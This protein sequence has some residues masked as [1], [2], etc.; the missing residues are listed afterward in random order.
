MNDGP[1]KGTLGGFIHR[2]AWIE[3]FWLSSLC[4]VLGLH[5]LG[6]SARLLV[7]PLLILFFVLLSLRRFAYGTW[8]RRSQIDWPLLLLFLWVPIAYWAAADKDLAWHGIFILLCGLTLAGALSQSPPLSRHPQWYAQALIAIGGLFMILS[9][10]YFGAAF[11]PVLNLPEMLDAAASGLR[12]RVNV[13]DLAGAVALLAP[14]MLAQ[15]IGQQREA[16][17]RRLSTSVLA[18]ALVVVVLYS[19]SVGAGVALGAGCAVVLLW[20]WPNL[21]YTAPILALCGAIVIWLVGY[22][23]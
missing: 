14:I 9:A 18:L 7:W 5:I 4:V 21:A 12:R 15:A 13:N 8:W 23:V 1:S 22:D 6:A 10:V 20:R 19:R 3:L 2:I 17:L 11:A 16:F